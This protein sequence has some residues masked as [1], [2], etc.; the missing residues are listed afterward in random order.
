MEKR[1]GERHRKT[2]K[3]RK[4]RTCMCMWP[5][6][7]C[8][9][10][11]ERMRVSE[12][13]R[14]RERAKARGSSSREKLGLCAEHTGNTMNVCTQ[15]TLKLQHTYLS[16]SFAVLVCTFSIHSRLHF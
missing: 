5:L 14:W 6:H 13:K 12:C 9:R 4:V 7:V 1:I 8:T 15:C 11:S 3:I 10:E 2:D 16:V